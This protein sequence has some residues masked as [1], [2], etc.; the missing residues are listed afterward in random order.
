MR[1]RRWLELIKDYYCEILYHPGKANV[2]A[3]A[4][5]RK[6]REKLMKLTTQEELVKD[7]E[8]MELEVRYP[9]EAEEQ[10]MTITASP[11]LLDRI[12]EVQEKDDDCDAIKRN[13]AENEE[14]KYR[15]DSSGILRFEG[16]IWIPT[17][18]ELREE[19]PVQ[20]LDLKEQTLRNKVIPLV[21]VLWRNH[22]VEEATWE[23]ETKISRISLS[24]YIFTIPRTEFL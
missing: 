11:T 22:A 4:L 5:S 14:S 12:K 15:V 3:Y 21:K 17:D 6:T 10:L 7:F 9:V 1:Q 24:S 18:P 8:R 23:L 16:R 2:V 20:I 19:I 13:L